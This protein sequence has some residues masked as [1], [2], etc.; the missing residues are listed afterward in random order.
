MPAVGIRELKSHLSHYLRLVQSGERVV[1]TDRGHEIAVI[2]QPG[3]ERD[4]LRR[5]MASG[6]VRW[7]GGKPLVPDGPPLT[8]AGGPI[9]QTV[10]D[11][12]DGE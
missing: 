9:S 4:A 8:I 7:S 2:E 11:T 10:L 6:M 3:A 5:L 1:V 12:R